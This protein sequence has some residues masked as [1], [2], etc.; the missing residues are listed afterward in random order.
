VLVVVVL[1]VV[2]LVVVVL[3]GAGPGGGL[4]GS[5]AGIA[6]TDSWKDSGR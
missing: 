5:S 3:V 1:V 4:V 2:G 6:A